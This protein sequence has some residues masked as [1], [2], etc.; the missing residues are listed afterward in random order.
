MVG[1]SEGGSP[2]QQ[3]HDQSTGY[4]YYWN[5][6]TNEVRWDC[7]QATLAPPGLVTNISLATPQTQTT[8]TAARHNKQDSDN[9]KTKAELKTVKAKQS[10]VSGYGSD[11]DDTEDDPGDEVVDKTDD[12]LAQI[13]AEMPPDYEQPEEPRNQQ[14]PSISS[15]VT[16]SSNAKPTSSILALATNYDD[17]SDNEEEEEDGKKVMKIDNYGRMVFNQEDNSDLQTEEQKQAL[18]KYHIENLK[19]ELLRKKNEG[20]VES[21]RE[22]FD[23]SIPGS[24][25]RRLDLPGGKFNKTDNFSKDQSNNEVRETMMFVPFVKSSIGIA[26]TI[27]DNPE[28]ETKTPH[29]EDNDVDEVKQEEASKESNESKLLPCQSGEL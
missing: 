8:S 25:K 26:G 27:G 13:E 7:P 4:P 18:A 5:T 15:K 20:E 16:G 12:L 3:C 14:L 23:N 6:L 28:A 11:E 24:R 21:K 29:E 19:S 10:L 9:I 17:D 1:V 2:W 22:R